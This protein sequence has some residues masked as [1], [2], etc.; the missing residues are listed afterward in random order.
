MAISGPHC[1]S[2][3]ASQVVGGGRPALHTLRLPS[4]SLR[5][6]AYMLPS[7]SIHQ[8]EKLISNINIRL[9]DRDMDTYN[10]QL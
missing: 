9:E 7:V 5:N 6:C 4:R 10:G 3:L 2:V 1:S 8:I